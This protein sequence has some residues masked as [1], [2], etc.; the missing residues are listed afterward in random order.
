MGNPDMQLHSYCLCAIVLH[1]KK[2]SFAHILGILS[3]NVR[4][5][6]LRTFTLQGNGNGMHKTNVHGDINFRPRSHLA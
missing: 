4:C 3:S 1:Q 5:Y 6:D 2:C